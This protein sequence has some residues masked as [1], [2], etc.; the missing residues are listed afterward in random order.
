MPKLIPILTLLFFFSCHGNT[1]I[2]TQ[3]ECPEPNVELITISKGCNGDKCGYYHYL[4]LDSYDDDCFNKYD[5]VYIADK[6]LDSVTGYLPVS[7]ITFIKPFDFEPTGDSRE[8][9][10]ID[11]HSIVDIYYTDETMNNKVPEISSISIWANGKRKDLQYMHVS[12][13]SQR[14]EYYHTKKKKDE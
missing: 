14:M 13:R 7:G 8:F 6:Y 2:L 1:D 12:S 5:F 3:E 4:M 10:P 11:K 9:E